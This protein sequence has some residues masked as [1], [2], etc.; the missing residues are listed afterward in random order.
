MQ[1]EEP[2]D[3]EFPLSN[4]N[5][6]RGNE[7]TVSIYKNPF[8]FEK[9]GPHF[10]EYIGICIKHHKDEKGEN[11]E[12][13]HIFPEH[14]GGANY[15]WNKVHLDFP[16]HQQVHVL[17]FL[18]FPDDEGIKKS[19]DAIR[20][21]KCLRRTNM[22]RGKDSNETRKK[23]S[24]SRKKLFENEEFRNENRNR[25]IK[26]YEENPDAGQKLGETLKA[27]P[28]VECPH[29]K[30]LFSPIGIK[31]HELTCI[32]NPNRT[33]APNKGKKFKTHKRVICKH[34]NKEIG[35]GRIKEHESTCIENPESTRYK[36]KHKIE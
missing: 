8:V 3:N 14:K 35:E 30:K 18:A 28:K 26:R 13:H 12:F 36:K 25:V 27:L 31:L 24:E 4:H 11:T 33:E 16:I 2:T 22:G 7:M 32:K 19:Y 21:R 6:K 10:S 23:K 15:R 1:K 17:L 20:N 5:I 34:C 9:H 29:C